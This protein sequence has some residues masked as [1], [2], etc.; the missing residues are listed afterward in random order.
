MLDRRE[1]AEDILNSVDKKGCKHLT[2][3]LDDWTK[4]LFV[5]L[6]VIDRSENEVVAGDLS[7][8]LNVSTARMA[9]ALATLDAKKWIKKHKSK[10]DAR[11]TVV[12][13]TELGKTK[14]QEKEEQLIQ[15]MKEFLDKLDEEEVMQL[16]NIIKKT[17]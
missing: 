12:E 16:V 9:V 14:L 13:L 15:I 6:R 4:G 7:S 8:A 1:I 3:F 11:K 17:L 2:E 5:I 10:L